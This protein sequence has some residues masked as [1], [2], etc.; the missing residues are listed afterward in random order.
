MFGQCPSCSPGLVQSPVISLIDNAFALIAGGRL[1][2]LPL[3]LGYAYRGSPEAPTLHNT[4][5]WLGARP[6]RLSLAR[7]PQGDGVGADGLPH[8]A[9]F[10]VSRGMRCCG[11]DRMRRGRLRCQPL[12]SS[13]S[14][15][16]SYR[17]KQHRVISSSFPLISASC[18]G[19]LLLAKNHVSLSSRAGEALPEWI[20]R[21][22]LTDR[23]AD[24]PR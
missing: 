1:T 20:C 14:A 18:F 13:A 4:E 22:R 19:C 9:G 3:G 12:H 21:D 5:P 10:M 8:N 17:N 16:A 15:R 24:D 23:C 7:S 2:S 11:V 6:P